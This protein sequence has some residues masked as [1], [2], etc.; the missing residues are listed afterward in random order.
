MG[1]IFS[2][3]LS[4]STSTSTLYSSFF[5]PCSGNGV[6]AT[7]APNFASLAPRL[8]TTSIGA[9]PFVRII[10]L[11]PFLLQLVYG[12]D[13]YD[14]CNLSSFTHWVLCMWGLMSALHDQDYE[15]TAGLPLFCNK[16]I[17]RK[18]CLQ[19]ERGLWYGMKSQGA[20]LRCVYV[21]AVCV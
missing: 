14:F 11:S 8:K 5:H 19:T 4:T 20:R 2:T 18:A 7:N 21:S 13:V 10:T 1:K 17:S 16:Y 9:A 12:G 6:S 15:T 3:G